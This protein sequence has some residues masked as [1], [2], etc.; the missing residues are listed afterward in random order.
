MNFSKNPSNCS[1]LL[2]TAQPQ[3][4]FFIKARPP[5]NLNDL[6]FYL[7]YITTTPLAS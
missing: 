7:L 6:N 3:L 5:T 2:G 1:K 4:V